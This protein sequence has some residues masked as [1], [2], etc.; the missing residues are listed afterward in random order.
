MPIIRVL[1][2]VVLFLPA[3]GTVG[4]AQPCV[5]FQLAQSGQATVGSNFGSLSCDDYNQDGFADVLLTVPLTQPLQL[6]YGDGAGSF[7]VPVPFDPGYMP[8]NVDTGDFNGDGFLDLLIGTTG[9]NV[10]L[11][12]GSSSGVFTVALDL[13]VGSQRSYV[14]VGD[15]TADGNLDFVVTRQALTGP[16]HVRLYPGDGA[17]GFANPLDIVSGEVPDQVEIADFD[18]NGTLDLAVGSVSL[19]ATA[20]PSLNIHYGALSGGV[21]PATLVTNAYSGGFSSAD[22]NGDGVRDFAVIQFIP[23]T[24]CGQALTIHLSTATGG[25]SAGTPI[26]AVCGPYWP[27]FADFDADGNLDLAYT[28][29]GDFVASAN[30]LL[31]H[32]GDGAGNFAAPCNPAT[33]SWSLGRFATPDLNNDQRPDFVAPNFGPNGLVAFLNTNPILS[34]FVRGDCNDDGAVNLADA[35]RGLNHLFPIGTPTPLSCESACDANDDD[36]LNLADP[37]AVLNALFSSPPTVLPGPSVCGADP[38]PALID[39]ATFVNCP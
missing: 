28:D 30:W 35:V 29:G 16:S 23:I 37:V 2:C 10:V 39:C 27:R 25:Y 20:Q 31:I 17:G 12:T 14:S 7:T 22:V 13:N 33:G 21:G 9:S 34:D 18:G 38:T 32:L 15:L 36:V 5:G 6:I 19:S 11:A 4:R 24:V 8:L 26:T 3:M 1:F